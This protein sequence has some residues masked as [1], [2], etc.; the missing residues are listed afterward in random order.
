MVGQ[1]AI[2]ASVVIPAK[3]AGALFRKVLQAVLGQKTPWRFEVLVIDSG[4]TDGTLEYCRN[5]AA[6]HDN[7]RVHTI[8]AEEFGHGRTRNLGI[9][10][11][12]GEFVAL[13]T[14]DA[15][16]ANEMWLANLVAAVERAP[17]VAGAFGR[18]L[19]YPGASPYTARDLTRHFDGFLEWM[20]VFRRD[21]PQRY[22]QDVGFRQVLHF[23]SDNN[24]CV[25]RSVWEKYPYPDV[26][27]AE[28]Q[29]WAKQ[30][31]EAGFGK[32]YADDAVVYHSHD[33]SVLELMRRSF[34]E[35]AA[36]FAL[37]GYRLCPSAA[38]LAGQALRTTLAD[39]RYSWSGGQVGKHWKWLAAAPWRNLARQIGFYLGE[40]SPRLAPW[41]RAK[42]SL[43]KSLKAGR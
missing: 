40:R 32:A 35:S 12:S 4:S 2:K 26:D 8:P 30:I 17:D 9:S 19:P 41:L 1:G 15:L 20:L 37:F 11:T 10:M 28:D 18:H 16:P 14:H 27:F 38:H 33:Y 6:Q 36:L 42:I 43:D 34:D 39:W 21:D 7:L 13:I 25:R 23:F 5:L 29:I 22:E 3:N 24:A 31:I